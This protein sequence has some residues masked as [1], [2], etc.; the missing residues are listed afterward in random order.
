MTLYKTSLHLWELQRDSGAD[1]KRG[2]QAPQVPSKTYATLY[3]AKIPAWHYSPVPGIFKL[4][5]RLLFCSL[6]LCR[7]NYYLN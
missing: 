4:N 3:Q 2:I 6:K 1:R 7:S 5:L